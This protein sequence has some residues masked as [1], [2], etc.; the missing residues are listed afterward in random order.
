MGKL[1]L[2]SIHRS[3][4]A[5][6]VADMVMMV[7]CS[8]KLLYQGVFAALIS[9]STASYKTTTLTVSWIEQQLT[10][11]GQRVHDSF[12]ATVEHTSDQKQSHSQDC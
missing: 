8:H 7:V 1:L 9:L 4:R 3:H 10:A 11:R 6:A 5:A 2:Y 12:N